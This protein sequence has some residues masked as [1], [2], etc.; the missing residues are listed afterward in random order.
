MMAHGIRMVE[1]FLG[2]PNWEERA[3]RRTVLDG[4]AFE[5]G[6]CSYLD[7]M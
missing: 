2:V 6:R 1:R 4:F 7:L 5:E 3:G